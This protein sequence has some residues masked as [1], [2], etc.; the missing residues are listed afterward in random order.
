MTWDEHASDWD[1]NE[2]VRRYSQAAFESLSNICRERGLRLQGA[3]VCDFGCGTGLLTEKL[4]PLCSEVF[5]VDTSRKMIEV[6]NTKLERLDLSNVQTSADA[7][8]D[9]VLKPQPYGGPRV[10]N[11]PGIVGGSIS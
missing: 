4:A 1:G 11:R 6:L 8:G 10:L 7:I 3:R 2:E 5:A 9:P